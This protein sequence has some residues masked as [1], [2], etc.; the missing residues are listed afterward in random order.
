MKYRVIFFIFFLLIIIVPVSMRAQTIYY[1]YRDVGGEWRTQTVGNRIGLV[2]DTR[3]QMGYFDIEV[4]KSGYY[5]I[6]AYIMHRWNNAWPMLETRTLQDDKVVQEG[7]CMVE[8]GELS[9]Q[10]KGRWLIKAIDKGEAPFLEKGTARVEFRLNSRKDIRME[11]EGEMEG[12]V[13]LWSFIVI[14]G[15]KSG[16]MNVLESERCR[17]DWDRIE[18]REEDQCGIIE[19]IVDA[20][21]R[22]QVHIPKAGDYQLSALLRNEG[23]TQIKVAV[24]RYEE[25]LDTYS[26][27]II[28]RDG[29]WKMQPLM[30]ASFDKGT[31]H[32]EIQNNTKNKIWIDSFLLVP[33]YSMNNGDDGRLSCSTVFFYHNP[34]AKNLV[35]GI[36]KV[37]DTGFQSVDIVAYDGRIGFGDDST[38]E[39]VIQI[40][41][42]LA[43]LGGKVASVHFGYIPLRTEDEAMERIR[44]AVWVARLLGAKRIVAPASLDIDG[45][46]GIFLSKEEGMLRLSSVLSQVRGLL[47]KNDI[48]LGLENHGDKQWLFQS[49]KDFLAARFLLSHHV[50]FVLD[51]GHFGHI[52]ED[53][54]QVFRQLL[55]YSRYV[56]FKTRDESRI[57]AL[58][59]LLRSYGYDGDISL[60]VEESGYMLSDWSTLY[61]KMLENVF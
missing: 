18:Y 32:V 49:S 8:P 33:H 25:K 46:L 42:L 31:Y 51:E 61:R 45:D 12:E 44:W 22:L 19:S 58:L 41:T 24:S 16:I 50:T 53:P 4:P 56:H 23:E 3:G 6:Y 14:P 54:V 26:K 21:A 29:F 30:T 57:Q 47:E 52:G 15:E 40:R 37:I 59:K 9:H 38:Q 35:E 48:E 17:G 28:D 2:A 39:A 43:R 7:Y 20:P 55:P 36:T 5:K 60:E 10:K 34:G 13:Y 11:A 27:I 1:D